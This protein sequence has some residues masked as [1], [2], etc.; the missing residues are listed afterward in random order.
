VY[1]DLMRRTPYVARARGSDLLAHV[2][3]SMEQAVSGKA[4]PGAVGR[5]GEALLVL[6]GHDT[7]LSN[8]SG[9]MG[10]SW[11]LP[12]YQPDDTPPGGALIFS[13]W[14]GAD[15]HYFVKLR[16]VAQ[17]LDQMRDAVPL[18]LASPPEGQD[19]AV[20]GCPAAQC[21]WAQAQA[22]FQKAIDPQFVS[23]P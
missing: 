6:S 19:V 3:R 12:G 8:L 4:T 5:P 21:P 10:L 17:S 23:V 1:A 22:A 16:Y 20:P 14:R 9:M 15:G 18:S 13:L 2:L 7:N 11:K